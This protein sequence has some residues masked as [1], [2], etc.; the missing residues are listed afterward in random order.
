MRIFWNCALQKAFGLNFYLAQT[1]LLN[2]IDDEGSQNHTVVGW[3]QVVKIFFSLTFYQTL[4][5]VCKRC[6]TGMAPV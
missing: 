2:S 1:C 4:C 6:P 5:S 3:Y